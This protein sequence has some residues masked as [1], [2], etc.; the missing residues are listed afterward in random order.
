MQRVQEIAHRT[1][2]AA[3]GGGCNGIVFAPSG[4]YAATC[5]QDGVVRLWTAHDAQLSTEFRAGVGAVAAGMHSVAFQ[6][7]RSLVLG[8]SSD[9]SIKVWNM[10]TG[11]LIC[12]MTGA[13]PFLCTCS[14]CCC[15]GTGSLPG[16][17]DRLLCWLIVLPI[18]CDTA[19]V[20]RPWH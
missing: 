8:A 3:H 14:A 13:F 6:E 16:D 2:E 11:S 1:H 15:N 9:R 10:H 20:F 12:T 18:F 17:L 7:E 5:G 19:T 4:S